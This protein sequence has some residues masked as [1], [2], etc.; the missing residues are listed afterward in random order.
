[1]KPVLVLQHLTTDG[2]A[3]LAAWLERE[4]VPFEVFDTQAGQRYPDHI[5]GYRALAVLGGEMS[6]NDELPS[7]RDA[8]RL[9]LEAIDRGVPVIGHC[10]GG[11]LMARALGATVQASPAP[12]IGWQTLQVAG[13]PAARDWFGTKERPTVFHWHHEAFALPAQAQRL[14]SSP[15]CPNQAFALGPHLAMQFHVELDDTKLRRWAASQDPDY[16][17]LQSSCATVQSGAVMRAQAAVALPAQQRLA[18]RL[19]QRWLSACA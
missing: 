15:A 13:T 5:D 12:E 2:P 9:I 10:L 16:L 14:A 19:Y 1:M 4:A 8:E 3:H 17:A 7:L 6:A 18:E 11:Q